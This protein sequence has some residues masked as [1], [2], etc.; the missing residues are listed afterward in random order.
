[1]SNI[2]TVGVRLVAHNEA[3]GVIAAVASQM[4]HLHQIINNTNAALGRFRLAL[5]GAAAGFAGTELVKTMAKVVDHGGEMLKIQNQMRAGGWG[6]KEVLDA[7]DQAFRL[8]QK[9]RTI[10][11]VKILEMQKEMAPV[12]GDRHHALEIADVMTKLQVSMQG[13]LGTEKAASFSKQIRDAVRAPELAGEALKP[14]RFEKYLTTMVRALNAFGGTVTPSDFF[15]ATKYGRASA[16]NWSERFTGEVLP[17][18]MQELGASSTGTAFMT[19]Y[20]AVIGGRMKAKAIDQWSRLGLIDVS[21][22]DPEQLTPEGRIRSMKPEAFRESRTLMTD[23]D[24]WM[25]NTVIPALINK[26]VISQA[27]LNEIKA[28]NIKEGLGAE[29]RKSITEMMALLF[30]DRTAQ[31]MADILALQLR[32]LERDANLIRG[33]DTDGQRFLTDDYAMSKTAVHAQWEALMQALAGPQIKE[34]TKFLNSVAEGIGKLAAAVRGMPEATGIAIKGLAAFGVALAALG[35]GSLLVALVGL[36]GLLVAALVGAMVAALSISKE[37]WAPIR[38]FFQQV[39]IDIALAVGEMGRAIGKA[40]GD[41]IRSIPAMVMGAI[42]SMAASIGSAISGA[43]R[44]LFG[45]GGAAAPGSSGVPNTD[46]SGAVIPQSYVPPASGGG[47]GNM[48]VDLNVDGRRLAQAVVRNIA[49][50]SQ[51][52]GGSA[53]FDSVRSP[54]PVD[55]DA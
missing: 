50:H 31:G 23:P 7:T 29:T 55:Y 6:E 27:G 9:Y 53:G 51:H 30:G 48:R 17:T 22:L 3:H 42:S 37:Q 15:M 38:I 1:M 16:L 41:A 13:I 43:F 49:L 54:T 8:S 52:T 39:A 19:M 11:P 14:E 26:G 32:K 44:S 28:G 20:S 36:P 5:V 33:A 18:I 10:D 40:L 25:L 24:Q 21:K 35:T 12:L 2:Y 34:A 4:L 47:G 46:A 45:G